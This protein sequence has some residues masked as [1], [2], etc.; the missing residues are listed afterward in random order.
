[1]TSF[2]KVNNLKLPAGSGVQVWSAP[3][4]ADAEW[5][6]GQG[7]GNGLTD[8]TGNGH[9]LTAVGS[10]SWVTNGIQFGNNNAGYQTD[11]LE[12]VD[13]SYVVVAAV[14]AG[15]GPDTSQVRFAG[16]FSGGGSARVGASVGLALSAVSTAN[17]NGQEGYAGFV[18]LN[19]TT[20]APFGTVN[21]GPLTRKTE[22]RFMGLS[23]DSVNGK[24]IKHMPK[25]DA[26][27]PVEIPTDGLSGRPLHTSNI[28]IGA[29]INPGDAGGFGAYQILHVGIWK[30]ALTSAQ[31]AAEYRRLKDLYTGTYGAI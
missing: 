29:W 31:I 4:V 14:P 24:L 6:F 10:P 15:T 27:T 11:M 30:K 21:Y 12:S 5:Q 17:P 16:T 1:M 7:A 8:M 28:R 22:L 19:S 13:M 26:A 25:Y 18:A 2:L 23:I 9:V 3:I 20:V